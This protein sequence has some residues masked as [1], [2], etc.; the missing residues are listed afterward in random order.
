MGAEVLKFVQDAFLTSF[1]IGTGT[2]CFSKPRNEFYN[3]VSGHS[4]RL[5]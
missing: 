3:F 1:P 2:A 4:G 5:M